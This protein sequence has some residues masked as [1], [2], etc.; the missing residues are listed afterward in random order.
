MPKVHRTDLGNGRHGW[1][2][3]CPGCDLA[4]SVSD[5]WAFNGDVDRPT[6]VPSIKV[7]CSS[8]ANLRAN[9]LPDLS[10]EDCPPECCHSFVTD[11]RIAYC[12]DST[13]AL[14]GQ[15]VELPEW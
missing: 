2:F 8:R 6:F 12:S 13:H 3:H 10:P 11:G 9:P 15:T 14:A 7:T 1:S 4:H 5:L